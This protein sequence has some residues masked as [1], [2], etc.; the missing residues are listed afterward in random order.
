MSIMRREVCEALA[1]GTVLLLVQ[2]CG[3]GGG[4]A[5][6]P[7]SAGCGAGGADI[8]LNHGHVLVIFSSDLDSIVDM[9]YSIRGSSDHDHTVTLSVPQLQQ[10]KA[11]GSVTATAS[12]SAAH[13][14]V[15]TVA[16]TS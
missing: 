4:D 6:P 5:T 9:T 1:A 8:S 12:V 15:A 14:H 10:L 7:R 11:G 3:G 13:S 16:C 2:G